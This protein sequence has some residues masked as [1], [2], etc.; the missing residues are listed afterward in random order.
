MT[1]FNIYAPPGT[2]ASFFRKIFDLIA[3]ETYGTLVCAGD[4]NVI[5][6]PV[7]DTTN[8]N[9]KKNGSEKLINRALKEL[10]LKDVWRTLHRHDPGYTFYSGRHATHSRLD[11]FFMYSKDLHRLKDCKIGQRDLSD[12][13]GVYITLHF[14]GRQ[15]KTLWRLNTG[16]LND[17]HFLGAMVTELGIYLEQNDNGDVNPSI[18]WDASKAV[19]RGKII[20]RTAISK[21]YKAQTH[22]QV[23]KTN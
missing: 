8:T 10:G 5:L 7:L 1:L 22:F 4:F 21:K 17:A 14:E 18:L 13:S 23:C 20:A 15:R 9:R 19:L 16:L 12:H 2:E 6:N 11:Y 3:L